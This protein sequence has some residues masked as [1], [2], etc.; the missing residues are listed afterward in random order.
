[1]LQPP[2]KFEVRIGDTL[3]DL[4]LISVVTLTCNLLIS[5]PVSVIALGW[6]T[7]LPILVFMG[8]FVLNIFADKYQSDG[9]RDLVTLTFNL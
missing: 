3:S 2:S 4:A 6:A 8:L 1:M 5:N 7:S 9:R